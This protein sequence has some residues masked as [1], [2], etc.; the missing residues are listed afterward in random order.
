MGVRRRDLLAVQV[1]VVTFAAAVRSVSQLPDRDMRLI[2]IERARDRA[3]HLL[4][5]T[6]A[7]LPYQPNSPLDH[8]VREGRR[9]IE[10]HAPERE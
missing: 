10:A 5:A 9:R 8:V 7:N 1:V 2:L 3:L 6:A 4:D